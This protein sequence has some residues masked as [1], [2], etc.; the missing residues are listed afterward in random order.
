[1]SDLVTPKRMPMRTPRLDR[2][3]EGLHENHI[4]PRV[5]TQPGSI[6]DIGEDLAAK[7]ENRAL[8]VSDDVLG[9][10]TRADSARQDAPQARMAAIN[11]PTP[12]IRIT[13]FMS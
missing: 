7:F 2:R 10:A 4:D 5:F 3:D 9:S 6:G 13:H 1:V 12:R 11:P 8:R